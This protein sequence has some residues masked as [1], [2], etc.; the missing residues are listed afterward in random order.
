MQSDE[1]QQTFNPYEIL[2]VPRDANEAQIRRAFRRQARTAHPDGGGSAEAFNLLTRAYEILSDK[3]LRR[4]YDETGETGETPLDPHQ[5]KIIEVLSI[6]L[7]MAL[8]KQASDPEFRNSNILQL[9]AQEI[10]E[11]RREWM[12][13]RSNYEQALKVSQQLQ[14]RFEVAEGHNLLGRAVRGRIE[15]CERHINALDE[16]IALIDETLAWL[17]T[18]KLKSSL[19]IES[20]QS[21][22]PERSNLQGISHLF[23]WSQLIR[24]N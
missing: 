3:E 2:G 21:P 5:A 13:E 4:R 1:Q 24:F 8:F 14:D 7:D 15:A 9:T 11:K 10:T 22:K 18:A 23:D 12:T 19:E 16:R 6:G 20:A 17:Q